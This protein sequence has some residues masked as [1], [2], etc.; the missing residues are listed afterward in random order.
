MSRIARSY[1]DFNYEANME[2][3]SEYEELINEINDLGRKFQAIADEINEDWHCC[4][5]LDTFEI[6][7]EIESDARYESLSKIY[8]QINE[9]KKERDNLKN[10]L[11]HAKVL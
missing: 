6:E 5:T 2:M 3:K 7:E 11:K 9:L 10:E 4:I 1:Y 8:N